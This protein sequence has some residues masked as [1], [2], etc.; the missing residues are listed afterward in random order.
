MGLRQHSKKYETAK[1]LKIWV[2][3]NAK[4][5]KLQEVWVSGRFRCP[6]LPH[7]WAYRSYFHVL[8]ALI[9]AA[10]LL[11]IRK[12]MGSRSTCLSMKSENRTYNLYFPALGVVFLFLHCVCLL[13]SLFPINLW[14]P[15]SV[16][17]DQV[18]HFCNQAPKHCKG[19]FQASVA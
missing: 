13:P 16:I 1:L 10:K 2:C 15:P 4:T 3:G 14:Q 18:D 17:D 6:K 19:W 7:F 11:T 5:A 9:G 8:L 12:N